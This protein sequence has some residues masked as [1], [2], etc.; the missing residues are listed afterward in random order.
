MY[1]YGGMRVMCRHVSTDISCILHI[2]RK[3][4][5][6]DHDILAS[7]IVVRYV[8]Y[9]YFVPNARFSRNSTLFSFGR[10][11]FLVLPAARA[12]RGP[13]WIVPCVRWLRLGSVAHALDGQSHRTQ[14]ATQGVG[15]H[16]RIAIPGLRNLPGSLYFELQRLSSFLSCC[17]SHNKQHTIVVLLQL[18]YPAV[19]LQ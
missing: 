13:A 11:S 7:F 18:V 14:Q 17:K 10:G 15:S 3:C 8:S 4:A 12:Q 16:F 1:R 5:L 6:R 19:E 2:P 9:Y